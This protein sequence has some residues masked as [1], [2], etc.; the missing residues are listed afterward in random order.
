MEE[1]S[2]LGYLDIFGYWDDVSP[3]DVQWYVANRG[4]GTFFSKRG[5]AQ[6]RLAAI[7]PQQSR[8][9]KPAF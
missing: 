3:A 7:L 9:P 5:P 6:K 1:N 4:S 2:I 8:N